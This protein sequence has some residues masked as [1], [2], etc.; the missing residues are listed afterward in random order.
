MSYY[1]PSV[2]V[3]LDMILPELQQKSPLLASAILMVTCLDDANQKKRMTDQFL[4]H[5]SRSIVKKGHKSLDILWAL[6][7]CV[8]WYHSLFESD[9]QLNI[10]L[11]LALAMLNSLGL[12]QKLN[13][14]S[15]KPQQSCEHGNVRTTAE[16]RAYLG[17]FY[18][19]CVAATCLKD[20]DPLRY[21]SYTEECCHVLE[22]L[23]EHPTD[24]YLVRLAR[25][26]CMA[27]RIVQ[28]LPFDAYNPPQIAP[29]GPVE[30]CVK[31]LEAELMHMKPSSAQDRIQDSILALQ[32]YSLKLFLY[33]S[34]LEDDSSKNNR[35]S[36]RVDYDILQSSLTSAKD[37]FSTFS[38]L[39]PQYFLYL[40]YWVHQEYYHAVNSLSKFL[41][42]AWKGG[43]HIN[44]H[45]PIDV[46]TAVNMFI[47][48]AKEA[49][50]LCPPEE[51]TPFAQEILY[52][53]ISRVRAFERLHEARL[54]DLESDDIDPIAATRIQYKM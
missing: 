36:T 37:F 5:V 42:L 22:E 25:L 8:S 13:L 23:Q 29:S 50:Q 38:S 9:E 35:S 20:M 18:T 47:A 40:P 4:E 52:Q 3:P 21:T 51:S 43:E 19:T 33:K 24:M 15:G 39:A 12:H 31:H 49:I 6:L 11:H 53:L 28:K 7:V 14:T 2:V 16:R 48:K 54:A 30:T 34:A 32:Y 1:C 46:P 44:A 41:L 17:C 26:S 45:I 10:I 27:H